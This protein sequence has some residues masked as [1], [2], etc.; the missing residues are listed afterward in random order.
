MIDPKAKKILFAQ[1]WCTTGWRDT[2]R[3]NISAEDLDYAKANGLMFDPVEMN[4][5]A[6]VDALIVER[7]KIDIAE[8]G[9]AFLASLSSRRLDLRSALGSFAVARFFPAHRFDL[10]H[11]AQL[12]S[13]NQ[14]C[15]LCEHAVLTNPE[16]VDLNVLNFERFKVGG[17]RFDHL[18]YIWFDLW[19]FNQTAKL[20]P[21]AED[22]RTMRAILDVI[23]QTPDDKRLPVTVKALSGVFKSNQQERQVLC[24]MLGIA[25]VL[26]PKGKPSYLDGW[27][28]P[29]KR[30]DS[31]KHFDD[32]HYPSGLWHGRDGVNQDA[33]SFWFPGLNWS[34]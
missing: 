25:G 32:Y 29:N 30:E 2:R 28:A 7:D 22:L 8:I 11:A 1:H 24:D 15:Q 14:L 23:A 16:P 27:V 31:G 5:D 9:R 20:D 18:E 3:L 17:V 33:V 12:P 34:G 10:Q 4:H 13:G 26:Q 19:R 21:N 6:L